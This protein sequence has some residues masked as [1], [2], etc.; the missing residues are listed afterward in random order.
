MKCKYLT[1]LVYNNPH[2]IESSANWTLHSSNISI[3]FEKILN[4][5]IQKKAP[6]GWGL[7]L[8]KKQSLIQD[9]NGIHLTKQ[10]QGS[11]LYCQKGI[12]KE[13]EAHSK[14]S[15]VLQ[16]LKLTLNAIYKAPKHAKDLEDLLGI[17]L[18]CDWLQRHSGCGSQD[19][20]S[21]NNTGGI[22]HGQGPS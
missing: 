16:E 3:N 5:V 18:R 2:L 7:G 17:N 11:S 9:F 12:D 15:I 13:I 21:Y 6:D 1:I 8:Q 20:S 19:K 14:M 22:F 10:R 4:K